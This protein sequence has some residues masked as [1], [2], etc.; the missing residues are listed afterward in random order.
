M[1]VLVR[2]LFRTGSDCRPLLMAD[3]SPAN[4]FARAAQQGRTDEVERMLDSGAIKDINAVGVN[5]CSALYVAAGDGHL[6]T[7]EVL[8]RRGAA[9]N[10]PEG[11][12]TALHSAVHSGHTDV[13]ALLL[14][15][16]AD[17]TAQANDWTQL[18]HEASAD[19]CTLLVSCGAGARGVITCRNTLLHLAGSKAR[20]GIVSLLLDEVADMHAIN[21]AG[22]TPLAE[23]IDDAGFLDDDDRRQTICQALVAYGESCGWM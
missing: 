5:H 10:A 3:D 12:L 20:S 21:E 16:G 19:L 1:H 23:T 8:L 11:K 9:V 18:Q 17:V 4:R 15:H 14:S 13:C 2:V 6:D 7:C 22:L